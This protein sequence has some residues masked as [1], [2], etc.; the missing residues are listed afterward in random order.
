MDARYEARLAD[1]GWKAHPNLK[2]QI[3][4]QFVVEFFVLKWSS[5]WCFV[6]LPAIYYSVDMNAMA[7]QTT[8]NTEDSFILY[9]QT[10]RKQQAFV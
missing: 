9:G 6:L 1:R 8:Y 5:R 4:S 3:S 10:A 2:L 7:I